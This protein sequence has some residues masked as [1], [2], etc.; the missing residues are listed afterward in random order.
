M[1]NTLLALLVLII[2]GCSTYGA[3]DNQALTKPEHDSSMLLSKLN[4]K[5][6]QGEYT[7]VVAMSGGGTRAAALSYGVLKALRAELHPKDHQMSMLDEVDVISSVSG[8]SF[9][10]AYYGL[11]GERIFD[12]F[13][14]KFL[15]HDV[16][17]DLYIQLLSPSV[18][19]ST[20]GRTAEVIEYYESQLFNN[21]TFDDFKRGNTPFVIINASDLGAGVRFSFIPEY[22]NLLCSDLESYS[23]ASAIAASSAVP[24]MFN[25]V[26][27]QNH[28][29]CEFDDAFLDRDFKHLSSRS[30]ETLF[31]LASYRHKERRPYIHLVDGG[32]T[33][34]LGLL[35]F[36]DI[37]ELSGGVDGYF[38][39][40]E[41]KPLPHY[42]IIS[43][44]ASTTPDSEIDDSAEEPGIAETISAITGIQL[45][46]YNTTTKSLIEEWGKKYQQNMQEEHDTE[47]EFYFVSIELSFDPAALSS[48][49][50]ERRKYLNSIPTDFTLKAK[51]VDALIDE[52]YIQLQNHPQ[53][54]RFLSNIH[55]P[56]SPTDK[57]A[58]DDQ[59]SD[60]TLDK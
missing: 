9:T 60:E 51:Q 23:V 35:S 10:A 26:V 30:K 57:L 47:I 34:N 33:D 3:I 16:G 12:D 8:G 32:I 21:A 50:I 14:D 41:T 46:R 18:V 4:N 7:V 58:H 40:S 29:T 53:F 54:L 15:Y 42:V 24:L 36:I 52:G 5:L 45:H 6:T 39:Q 25:P 43:I 49:D 22:F 28:D 44:D 2:A 11:Y 37:L 48:Q 55:S 17:G 1:K 59:V 13:E 31:G 56:A 27:L 38:R 20:K 19:F